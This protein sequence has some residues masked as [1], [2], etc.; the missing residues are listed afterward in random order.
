MNIHAYKV[1]DIE[2]SSFSSA[3][4]HYSMEK[5]IYIIKISMD[6]GIITQN[7]V[8]DDQTFFLFT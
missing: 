6:S 5:L 4:K 3:S 8:Y 2:V 7:K 1:I